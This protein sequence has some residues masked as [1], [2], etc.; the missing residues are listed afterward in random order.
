MKLLWD[1]VLIKPDEP[2]TKTDSGL[3]VHEDW[4]T[5]PITGEVKAV[6]PEATTVK[7]GD[8]VMFLRYAV[9]DGEGGDKIA[10]EQ[11]IIGV[12]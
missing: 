9:I 6:G 5:L 12:L 8:R 11:H 4:K 7:T 10:K 3:Y 2:K 1:W